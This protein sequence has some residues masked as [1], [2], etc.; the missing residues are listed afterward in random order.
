MNLRNRLIA[1]ILK[2]KYDKCSE[3]EL[4]IYKK[5]LRCK[6]NREI[7]EIYDTEIRDLKECE[8]LLEYH[9]RQF[10]CESFESEY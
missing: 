9:N 5:K 2:Y 3:S 8:Q 4:L 6:S 10:L 7:Y 1:D